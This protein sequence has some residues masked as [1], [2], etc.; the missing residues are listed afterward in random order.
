MSR[1]SRREDILRAAE[2][3]F[4][5]KGFDAA[6][7]RNIADEAGVGLPLVVYHFETK[8]NLYRTIFEHHQHLNESRMRELREIDVTATDALEAAVSAFLRLSSNSINDERVANYLTIVLREAGD[9]HAYDRDILDALFDPMAREFIA[10]LSRIIPGK[11]EGFH[12]WAYLFAVGAHI[13]TNVG[14]RGRRIVGEAGARAR[15][16][17]LHSFI[18]A[19][20]RHG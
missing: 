4:A 10:T 1:P 19:G 15:L 17:Y 7:M 18:C 16:E 8:L 20:I 3:V 9:P 14:E 13:S 11:P 12:E 2:T 5:D 6:S